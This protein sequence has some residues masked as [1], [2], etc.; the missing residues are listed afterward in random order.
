MKL[1]KSKQKENFLEFLGIQIN[2][3]LE[4]ELLEISVEE[5]Y[6]DYSLDIVEN[7]ELFDTV[8]FRIFNHQRDLSGNSSFNLLFVNL[9]KSVTFGKIENLINSICNVYGKDRNGKSYWNET[10]DNTISQYWEGR[11]WILDKN[12]NSLKNIKSDCIQINLH[13]DLEK[14]ID[15]SIVGAHLLVKNY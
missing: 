6:T 15:F 11:E 4:S 5:N 1:F 3:E 9:E 7:F 2:Q 8:V 12:G 10:D 13:F 14:G